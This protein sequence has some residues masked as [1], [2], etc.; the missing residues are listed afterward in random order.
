[1]YV[2]TIAN[3]ENKMRIP[4]DTGTALNTTMSQYPSTVAEYLEFGADT[5]YDVDQLL[6]ALDLKGTQRP[7]DHS[8]MTAVVQYRAPYIINNT[9]P[10]IISFVL[11]NDVTLRRILDIPGLLV[12]GDFVDSVKGRLVCSELN[13]VFIVHL[14]PPGKELPDGA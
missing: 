7:I 4:V 10:L 12:M 11:G 9:S 1:M 6:T 14:D 5:Q 13:Q 3:D 8:S 2:G